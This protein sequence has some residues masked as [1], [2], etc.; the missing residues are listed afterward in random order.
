MKTKKLLIFIVVCFVITFLIVVSNQINNRRDD[1]MIDEIDKSLHEILYTLKIDRSQSNPYAYT[2]N[3]Q[4]DKIVDYG[5]K[6]L[7]YLIDELENSPN[8]GLREYIIAI[9]CNDIL[10]W[11][12][13]EKN[14]STGKE[15]YQ[16]YLDRTK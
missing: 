16:Y 15:W 12:M 13:Q 3:E 8:N 14:W 10:G 6:A 7:D 9:A 5:D 2:E 4:F 1:I 11:E